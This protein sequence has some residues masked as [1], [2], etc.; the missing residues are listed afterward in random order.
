MEYT[1]RRGVHERDMSLLAC[2]CKS[3]K[4]ANGILLRACVH[5]SMPRS[6]S[7]MFTTHRPAESSAMTRYVKPPSEI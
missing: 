7:N 5:A 1:V 6:I 2:L 3:A 4:K